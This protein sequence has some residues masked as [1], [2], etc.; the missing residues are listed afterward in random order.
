MMHRFSAANR[1]RNK[2]HNM[3]MNAT[4]NKTFQTPHEKAKHGGTK[5]ATKEQVDTNPREPK[6][7]AANGAVRKGKL[8]SLLGHSVISVMRAM[9]K[10]G[11]TFDQTKAALD[12]AKIPAAEHTIRRA[13]KRGQR[14]ELRIAPLTAKAL[15]V[16]KAGAGKTTVE[17]GS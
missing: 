12:R 4:K 16:L 13:L 1:Q 9:G 8:G 10:H 7:Q 17:K 15:I 2:Q 3:K 14:G 5:P 6:K 11:W